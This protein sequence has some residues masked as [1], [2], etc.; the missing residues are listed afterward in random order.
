MAVLASVAVA[1]PDAVGDE[2]LKLLAI[3]EFYQWD[4]PRSFQERSHVADLRAP[5]GLPTRGIE[6]IYY[7]ERKGSAE[8]PHRNSNLE[9]L[10]FRLQLTPLR[11]KI[12]NILDGFL[13][14]IPPQDEQTKE[15]KVWRIALHR[16][17]ARHFRTEEGKKPGQIILTPS[18]PPSDLQHFIN[19]GAEVREL[20]NRRMRLAMWGMTRFRGESQADD[21]FP[22]WREALAEAQALKDD[23]EEETDATSL[24][25]AGPMFVAAC[26]IRD[27]FSDVQATELGW[28][29]TVLIKEVLRKDA[30]GN[31]DTRV[32]RSVFDGSRPAA[33]VLPRL[34]RQIEDEQTKRQ[35]E[36]CL[37]VAVTHASEEV[38]DYVAEGIRAWL[39][40]IDAGLAKACIGGL[41]ALAAVENRIRA[42]HRRDLHYSAEAVEREVRSAISEIR[43]HIV[44][45]HTL[46]ALKSP[47]ID[48]ETHDWPKL[49]DA[50]S[51]ISADTNDADLKA[52]FTAILGA[53]LREAESGETP[54]SRRQ[55]SFE[56][57]HAFANLFARF[58]LARPALEAG[59]LAVPLCDSIEKCPRFLAVL[60]E[61]LPAEKDRVR[62]GAPF[63]TIWR[64]VANPVFKHELLR[65][66]SRHLWRYSVMCKLVH[67]LLFADV[68][69]KDGVKEWAP[70]TSNKDFV[71]FAALAVGNTPGGFG[72]LVSLLTTIGQVFLPDAV[73]W[74]GHAIQSNQGSDLLEDPNTQFELEVLLRNI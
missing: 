4:F 34:L 23:G 69:W 57:Q 74:L 61:S 45:R 25:L 5:L 35:I 48:L 42:S 72:A 36:E 12:W 3:R 38:R 21:P 2:V 66:G 40:E 46:D 31:F 20:F 33:F 6:N 65:K 39:W 62:S 10:V 56:F 55:V 60:L 37:A 9:E 67:I 14:S 49:L 44:T 26:V 15:D 41:I 71:E 28:C 7:H 43:E 22:N 13:A 29:R 47:Q 68:Q 50:L 52:F 53:L 8:L 51:M 73:K 19:E 30:E 54:G 16:M 27:H 11:E 63:W 64:S 1:Y 17:D 59:A 70:I 18:E 58:A 24:D 32:S